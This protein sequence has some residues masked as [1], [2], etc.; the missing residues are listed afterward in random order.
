MMPEKRKLWPD[1][2]ALIEWVRDNHCTHAVE[3]KKQQEYIA[4]CCDIPVGDDA[5]HTYKS[6]YSHHITGANWK[7]QLQ[8][9]DKGKATTTIGMIGDSMDIGEDDIIDNDTGLS[10]IVYGE[11]EPVSNAYCPI[12]DYTLVAEKG[13]RCFDCGQSL[14]YPD[15]PNSECPVCETEYLVEGEEC[16]MCYTDPSHFEQDSSFLSPCSDCGM[17]TPSTEYTAN[18]ST[19]NLCVA[20]DDGMKI[21]RKDATVKCGY[22]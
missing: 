2:H 20:L 5:M 18:G 15:E 11:E 6:D 14:E 8:G 22:R 16:H 9:D 12:C 13:S 1:A 4:E 10:L 19:C 7:D 17:P 21:R 3:A